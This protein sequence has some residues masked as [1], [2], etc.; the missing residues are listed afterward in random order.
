MRAAAVATVVM[1]L[2]VARSESRATAE[3][4]LKFANTCQAGAPPC[5]NCSAP[6]AL[7]QGGPTASCQCTRA[8]F[9][10]WMSTTFYGDYD[11]ALL[12]CTPTLVLS[13]ADIVCF[14]KNPVMSGFSDG[15]LSC[16]SRVVNCTLS[17]CARTCV[18]T[19]LQKNQECRDCVVAGCEAD[20]TSCTGFPSSTCD[21]RYC[22]APVSQII[23]GLDNVYFYAILGSVG[24][25]MLCV[26]ALVV[27][28]CCTKA[29]DEY[30]LDEIDGK[31]TAYQ[32]PVSALASQPVA[33]LYSSPSMGSSM[34]G[35]M[36][37][38]G[39]SRS[40]SFDGLAPPPGL[41]A[42]PPGLG[43]PSRYGSNAASFDDPYDRPDI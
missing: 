28:R 18:S 24:G 9:G 26:T 32:I 3:D 34:T 29:T 40:A 19:Q 1:S 22:V 15:C 12:Q 5:Q 36:T 42:P 37:G 25:I 13:P 10:F 2:C 16:F 21:D 35:S 27:Y 20:F 4:A 39:F 14:K 41:V 38:S 8:D 33:G 31:G 23:A 30:E 43:G 6:S 17:K 7:P 11:G